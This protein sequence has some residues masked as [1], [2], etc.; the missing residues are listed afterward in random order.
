MLLHIILPG[1]HCFPC[2]CSPG[3]K[4][5][6]SAEVIWVKRIYCKDLWEVRS[7]ASTS[8]FAQS[9]SADNGKTV[10]DETACL[11]GNS[12]LCPWFSSFL[13]LLSFWGSAAIASLLSCLFLSNAAASRLLHALFS[14][15]IAWFASL[16]SSDFPF[17]SWL[18]LSLGFSGGASDKEP[19][20]QCRRPKRHGFDP[21][22]RKIPWRKEW[23]PTP[24]FLLGE[25]RGQRSLAGCS[26]YCCKESDVTEV[27]QHAQYCL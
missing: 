15:G 7:Q 21:S 20:C 17:R 27:T 5:W 26:L 9:Q 1:K 2:Y 14:L 18:I 11:Y 12:L 3:C 25:S 6:R 22:G 19:A 16:Y 13:S 10:Q 8:W 23:Q 24:M 4:E